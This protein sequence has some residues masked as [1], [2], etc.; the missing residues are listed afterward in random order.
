MQFLM[1]LITDYKICKQINPIPKGQNVIAVKVEALPNYK[2]IGTP[3][4]AVMVVRDSVV[5]EI[6]EYVPTT[7]YCYCMAPDGLLKEIEFEK[8]YR[9]VMTNK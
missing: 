4:D 9:P 8:W 7:G 1:R 3:D 2:V 6:I 5:L